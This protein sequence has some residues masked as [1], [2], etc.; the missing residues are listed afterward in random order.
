MRFEILIPVYNREKELSKLLEALLGAK[1][2]EISP[3]MVVVSDDGSTDDTKYVAKFYSCRLVE[4]PH[5]GLVGAF[6]RGLQ[7]TK[8]QIVVYMD[9]DV[10]PETW[11]SPQIL[12]GMLSE[13]QGDVGAV[14]GVILTKESR[15][16]TFTYRM[17]GRTVKVDARVVYGVGLRFG[18][19]DLTVVFPD[20]YLF[21]WKPLSEI[22]HW[23]WMPIVGFGWV[24]AF[25]A[26]IVRQMG[27]MD[28]A[29]A[30]G[31]LL[32][33]A[34]LSFRL[35]EKGWRLR[36]TK[37]AIFYHPTNPLKSGDDLTL[38]DEKTEYFRQ[39]WEET[40]LYNKS[41]LD[42]E[43]ERTVVRVLKGGV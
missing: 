24:Y 34:D 14:Q 42:Q 28:E 10:E 43:A 8:E 4:G 19:D 21:N 41:S 25:R 23:E 35:R 12:A 1:D 37:R 20:Y 15:G 29:L 26:D 40:G 30:P 7:E 17:R 18:R 6:N 32:P 2:T 9:S 11:K 3:D 38:E 13:A 36:A 16:Q 27:G 33:H 5:T 31:H 39:R 22:P